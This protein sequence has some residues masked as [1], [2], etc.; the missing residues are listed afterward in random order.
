V[1]GIIVLVISIAA[2]DS[3]NPS[4]VIPAVV[5]ALGPSAPRRLVAF[6]TGVFLV[7]TL[8]GIVLLFSVGRPLLTRLAHPSPHAR[9]LVELI[10]GAALVCVATV[11]W[12]LRA[13]VRTELEGV[14]PGEGRSALVLGAGIM[15]VELPTAFPYFAAILAAVESARGAVTETVLV[16]AYNAVFVAP[17]VAV[18]VLAGRTDRE[19]L[20]RASALVHRWA[21]IAVPL[22][23]AGIGAVLVAVG[24]SAL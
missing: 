8:G 19:R 15:A 22:G 21:P 11:L 1:A 20:T 12:R 18:T 24:A 10:V 9:H 16:L 4:T 7:S 14:K 2:L 13:R 6:T 3:L 23:V 17:L 5:L